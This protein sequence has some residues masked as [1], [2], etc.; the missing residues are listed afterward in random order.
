MTE[1]DAG[2]AKQS[3]KP[4]GVLLHGW[5]GVAQGAAMVAVAVGAGVAIYAERATVRRGLAVLPHLKVGWL[6][7]AIGAECVSM[8]AFG[9]L[10]RYMLRAGGARIS[11]GSVLLAAYRANATAVAVPV[12]GSGIATAQLYRDFRR[13]GGQAA[14][15]SVALAVA[16]VVSSVA[17]AVMVTVGALLTGNPAAAAAAIAIAVAGVAAIAAVVLALRYPAA[18][19]R[20]VAATTSVLTVSKR[21]IRWPSADPE[22]MVNEALDTIGGLHLGWGAGTAAFTAALVNWLTDVACLICALK[23]AG[24]GVPWSAILIVWT[25]GAGAASF[26]P[27]P[28]GLGVVDIVLIAA[29]SGAGI[30]VPIAVAAVVLYRIATFKIIITAVCLAY[31]YVRRT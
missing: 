2:P 28:A 9:L 3:T 16:G 12:V 30:A 1:V 15:V 19:R 23:A 10:Q 17:F 27:S 6:L 7:A 14:Q 5:K 11:F 21:L 18:R 31:P 20:L 25:A 4:P 13:A 24:G 22:Q 29:L 26:S 8:I